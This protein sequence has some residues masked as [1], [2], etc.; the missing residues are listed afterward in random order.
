[1]PIVFHLLH[2]PQ[3]MKYQSLTPEEQIEPSHRTKHN[4]QPTNHI[5][6]WPHFLVQQVRCGLGLGTH[7][8][9][10]ASETYR[11]RSITSETSV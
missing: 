6:L 9:K 10:P 1:M 5:E 11:G 8:I 2:V 7:F 3:K 4:R